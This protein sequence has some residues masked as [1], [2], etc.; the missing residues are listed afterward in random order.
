[1][2]QDIANTVNISAIN[3]EKEFNFGHNTHELRK[4]NKTLEINDDLPKNI[5]YSYIDNKNILIS[6]VFYK[7]LSLNFIICNQFTIGNTK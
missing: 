2:Q 3:N 1:M 7:F 6:N 4:Q 5:A